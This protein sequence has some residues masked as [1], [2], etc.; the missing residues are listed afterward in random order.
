MRLSQLYEDQY[1]DLMGS[2]P[3]PDKDVFEVGASSREL[4]RQVY[5]FLVEKG[6]NLNPEISMDYTSWH[7]DDHIEEYDF[8]LDANGNSLDE[9][10]SEMIPHD[11]QMSFYHSP[12]VYILIAD[13]IQVARDVREHGTW[14]IETSLDDPDY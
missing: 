2:K 9:E 3:L 8:I 7:Y 1:D 12:S 6:A 4:A 10:L 11:L 13:D 5:A 14:D